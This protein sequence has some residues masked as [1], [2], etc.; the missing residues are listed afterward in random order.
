MVCLRHD[1]KR[2]VEDASPYEAAG[3][4]HPALRTNT[5]SAVEVQREVTAA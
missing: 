5:D 1:W 4:G 2:A 3:W